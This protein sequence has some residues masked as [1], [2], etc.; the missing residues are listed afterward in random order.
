LPADQPYLGSPI[1][2]NPAGGP[3]DTYSWNTGATDSTITVNASGIYSVTVTNSF[4]CIGTDVILITLANDV[5]ALESFAFQ[6]FPNPTE[7]FLQITVKQ[8]TNQAIRLQVTNA[9]GQVCMRQN[10]RSGTNQWTIPVN[11]LE[12]GQ[13]WFQL[14]FDNQPSAPQAIVI[15]R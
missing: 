11:R 13:Y 6:A 15:R 3:F 14:F 10:L 5:Q 4:G 2:L 12:N 9:L 7:D 8:P 1:T